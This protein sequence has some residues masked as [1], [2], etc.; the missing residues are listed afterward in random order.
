MNV[1]MSQ[2]MWSRTCFREITQKLEMHSNETS[3]LETIRMK[4][5]NKMGDEFWQSVHG[6]LKLVN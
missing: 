5:K 4:S 6:V 1:N 2:Y 3:H